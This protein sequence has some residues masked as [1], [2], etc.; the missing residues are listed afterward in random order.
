VLG[1]TAF[2][3]GRFDVARDHFGVVIDR[4]LPHDVPAHLQRSG[5]DPRIICLSRL[6][7]T[8]W[9]L[10]HTADAER[11][12]DAALSLAGEV[13]H[14]NSR[15]TAL[16]FA[17]VLAIEL[18]DW[19]AVREY[20]AALALPEGAEASKPAFVASQA[21]AGLIDV[22]DGRAELGVPRIRA[23][24]EEAGRGSHAPGNRACIER[25]LVAALV[26]ATDARAGLAAVDHALQRG[27]GIR[28]FDAEFRR[29][30]AE[31]LAALGEPAEEIEAELA[32]A[33]A[34]AREQ[35]ARGMERRIQASLLRYGQRTAE[36]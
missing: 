26:E 7:N 31:F 30:R 35:N 14:P 21:I 6:A 4:C 22:L 5:Q 18:R 24:L 12:R 29:A 10:G 8:L 19:R 32:R 13:A 36:R 23:A 2:W 25:V 27:A 34:V 20:G 9:F 16:V 33:M 15:S 3:R 11:A 28:V 17:T 1:V